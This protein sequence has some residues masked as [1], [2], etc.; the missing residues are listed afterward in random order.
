[1]TKEYKNSIEIFE[2]YKNTHE[3]NGYFGMNIW[4]FE[5]ELFKLECWDCN[6]GWIIV[7]LFKMAA[8]IIIFKSKNLHNEKI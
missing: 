1:M 5:N 2:K 3:V 6:E 7:Q 4:Q 8:G